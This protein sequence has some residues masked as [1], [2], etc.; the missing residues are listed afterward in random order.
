[1]DLDTLRGK[2]LAIVPDA[3]IPARTRGDDLYAFAF[4]SRALGPPVTDAV[5]AGSGD[6]LA[7]LGA[8]LEEVFTDGDDDL[9]DAVAIRVVHDRLVARPGALE[10]AWP[11]LGP[12]S[13]R[14]AGKFQALLRA[15]AE[16]EAAARARDRGE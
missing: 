2:L 3:E 5:A 16:R 1:M 6:L 4:A 10:A 9:V 8:L 13:R 14:V 11:Y 12:E 15:C 7:P